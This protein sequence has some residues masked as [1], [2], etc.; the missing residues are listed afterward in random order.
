MAKLATRLVPVILGGLCGLAAAQGSGVPVPSGPSIQVDSL[1]GAEIATP[2]VAWRSLEDISFVVWQ[3]STSVGHDDDG[4]SIQGQV[5]RSRVKLRDQ[6]QV[7]TYK[8][9]DQTAPAVEV[10]ADGNFVVSWASDDNTL[11]R[12][13]FDRISLQPGPELVTAQPVAGSIDLEPGGEFSASWQDGLYLRGQRFDAAGTPISAELEVYWEETGWPD[14][15]LSRQHVRSHDGEQLLAWSCDAIAHG[16]DY[17]SF[18]KAERFSPAGT[19]LGRLLVAWGYYAH[20]GDGSAVFGSQVSL[21]PSGGFVVAYNRQVQDL[22]LYDPFYYV[23]F[24]RFDDNGGYLFTETVWSSVDPEY[25]QLF[26][27][28]LAVE[29][30]DDVLVLWDDADLDELSARRYP[31][32]LPPAEDRFLISDRPAQFSPYTRKDQASVA[33][34]DPTSRFVVVWWSQDCDLPASSECLVIRWFKSYPGVHD[35]D[36][37]T[38]DASRW[39]T[40][41]AG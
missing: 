38:G 10:D 28:G 41:V 9:G 8:T 17:Q 39:C 15:G 6:F 30:D 25:H 21:V 3:S 37:E 27:R 11:R 2:M 1:A 33:F 22:L 31:S 7:N 18:V 12:R 24:A 34:A 13:I 35:D 36:F 20:G 40:T 19:S 23:R 5:F 29:V 32:G 4:T 16:G 14:P 26:L